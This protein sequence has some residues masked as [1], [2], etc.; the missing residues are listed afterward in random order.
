MAGKA[1]DAVADFFITP[2]APT[3]EMI[4]ARREAREEAEAARAEARA[5]RQEKDRQ[6]Q[7]DDTIRQMKEREEQYKRLG[8]NEPGRERERER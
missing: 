1:V 6:R 3:P 2:S 8:E 4:H 5:A 7:I